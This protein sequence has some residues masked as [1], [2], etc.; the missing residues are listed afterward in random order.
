MESIKN[1]LVVETHPAGTDERLGVP[2]IVLENFVYANTTLNYSYVVEL[3]PTEY[4][5]PGKVYS[6]G[7]LY[8]VYD[9]KSETDYP[10]PVVQSR[11]WVAKVRSTIYF[12]RRVVTNP[13]TLQSLDMFGFVELADKILIRNEDR[14]DIGKS[15][16]YIYDE[17]RK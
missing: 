5:N 9:W 4:P 13:E 8:V 7:R 1:V 12:K 10:T 17:R 14:V 3:E 15:M 6:I 16:V 2:L 11:N